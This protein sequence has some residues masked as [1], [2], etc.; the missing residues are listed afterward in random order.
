[1]ASDPVGKQ[2]GKVKYKYDAD[3]PRRVTLKIGEYHYVGF[4]DEDGDFVMDPDGRFGTMVS[5][6]PI[7]HPP[8]YTFTKDGQAEPVYEYR[9]GLLIKGKL[10]CTGP[11]AGLL[12]DHYWIFVPEIGSKVIPLKDYLPGRNALEIYNLPGKFVSEDKDK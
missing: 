6:V 3:A 8:Y 5:G 11:R 7:T 1:L 10:M 12:N 2:D 9:S 4:L